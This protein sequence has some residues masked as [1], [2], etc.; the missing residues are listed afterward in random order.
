MKADNGCSRGDARFRWVSRWIL[1]SCM[2]MVPRDEF[3]RWVGTFL[4]TQLSVESEKD[5]AREPRQTWDG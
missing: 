5:M 1:K 4:G 2:D 3:W